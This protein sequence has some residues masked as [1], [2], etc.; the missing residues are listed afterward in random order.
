LLLAAGRKPG[1]HQPNQHPPFILWENHRN[2]PAMTEIPPILEF[3]S[4][5]AWIAWL[6]KNHATSAGVWVRLAKKSC[7]TPMLAHPE[8]LDAA[9]CYGWIDAQR[10]GE[11]ETAWLQRFTPR[12]KKSFWSKINCA[13]AL[14]L[15]ESGRMQP[16]GLS[17]MERAKADG[18]W[19]AA[20]DS[21]RTVTVPADL[22][23]ALDESPEA[24]AFFATLNATNRYAILWRLQT[25]KTAA[26]RTKKIRQFVEM[27]EKKEKFHP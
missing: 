2:F 8:A 17:E 26:T 27:L 3:A 10:K 25:T 23:T 1:R 16:A 21:H 4:A 7:A 9:I 24:Q 19:D 15:I 14:A 6:A 11:S 5:K 22:Q 13:K 20:Y 18:R 12:A